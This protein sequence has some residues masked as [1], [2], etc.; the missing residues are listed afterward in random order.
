MVSSL[1][2]VSSD[3]KLS[4]NAYNLDDSSLFIWHVSLRASLA[5]AISMEESMSPVCLCY[6]FTIMVSVVT[7]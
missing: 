4:H 5:R 1:H 7:G 3:F 6:H 2:P